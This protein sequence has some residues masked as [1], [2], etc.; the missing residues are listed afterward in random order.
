MSKIDV[1]EFLPI[2]TLLTLRTVSV[3]LNSYLKVYN[4]SYSLKATKYNTFNYNFFLIQIESYTSC[5]NC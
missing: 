2:N 1:K 3:N 4:P 5:K